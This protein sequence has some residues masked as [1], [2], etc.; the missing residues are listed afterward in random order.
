MLCGEKEGKKKKKDKQATKAAAASVPVLGPLGA[1]ISA[2]SLSVCLCVRGVWYLTFRKSRNTGAY[3]RI[4]NTLIR[5][6]IIHPPL[7]LGICRFIYL[8]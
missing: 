1:N 4:E 7:L 5:Y 2:S 3:M 8:L 6:N